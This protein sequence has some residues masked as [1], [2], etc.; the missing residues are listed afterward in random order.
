MAGNQVV[1]GILQRQDTAPSGPAAAPGGKPVGDAVQA[2]VES[3][4][5][6]FA[7]AKGYEAQ[8]AA[9][10][11]AVR[12]IIRSYSMS[13]KGV[14]TMRFKPD[15]DPK[16]T[17]ETGQVKGNDRESEIDFGPTS[18]SQGFAFL[19][20]IV[21]HELEH[22]RQ[23]LIGGYHRGDEVEAVSEFLAYTGMV[24]QVQTVP[25]AAGR[26]FLGA[27]KA[28][29]GHSAPALPP[30]PPD[31]LADRA[32]Q[33]LSMFSRMSSEDQKKRQYRQEFAAAG[34][35]LFE[36]LKTEAPRGLRP[37][38]KFTPEWAPWYEGQ[39]PTLDILT[40]EY[41]EWQDAL[42]SPW[43]RV[44]GVW[45]QFDAAFKIR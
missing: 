12:A 34:A 5:K 25:G 41:Q 35:K 11:D 2:E 14:R 38:T 42:K 22:V 28:G 15:L 20:H 17:A 27:L 4:L 6:T 37:P 23:N 39:A 30:L 33:A 45:K 43:N 18:F 21:A 8:N 16:H 7:A 3:L 13:T 32:E 40:P 24:L 36:R 31:Q 1:A 19:V 44:K 26:G 10:M 29:T 9:A